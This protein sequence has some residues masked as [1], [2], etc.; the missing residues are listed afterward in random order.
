MS[1]QIGL[2]ANLKEGMRAG[3]LDVVLGTVCGAVGHDEVL[4]SEPLI[5][6]FADTGSIDRARPLPLCLFPEPCP[7]RAAVV[8]VLG[9]ANLEW[10]LTC[11][12]PSAAGVRTAA[13]LGFG[14]TPVVRSQLGDGLREIGPELGLPLLPPVEFAVWTSRQGNLAPVQSLME[15]VHAS[16][17]PKF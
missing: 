17:A 9:A 1:L 7:Y 4:W 10:R 12:S 3:H 11:V 14:V 5:W 2:A 13:M 8:S 15:I 6:A 16:G